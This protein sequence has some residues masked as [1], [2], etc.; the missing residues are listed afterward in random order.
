LNALELNKSL[1]NIGPIMAEKLINAGIN[2]PSKLRRLGA[3]KA[4][5]R[6]Y[7]SGG[8][9]TKF[10]PVYLYALEGAIQDC[11][12]QDIAPHLKREY[13]TFCMILRKDQAI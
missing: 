3:K 12:W 13:K 5:M 7:R 11:H 6:I 10:H 2:S 8:I 9:C 4:F 1:K